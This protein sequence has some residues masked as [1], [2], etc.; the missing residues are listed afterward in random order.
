[1]LPVETTT[2][3]ALKGL[4]GLVGTQAFLHEFQGLL[5]YDHSIK[6]GYMRRF[7]ANFST[8]MSGLCNERVKVLSDPGEAHKG[9]DDVQQILSKLGSAES[10]GDSQT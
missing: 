7:T 10:E 3:I 1:M 5:G 2:E 9:L 6:T 8:S 4:G